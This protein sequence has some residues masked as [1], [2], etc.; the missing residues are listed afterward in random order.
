MPLANTSANQAIKKALSKKRLFYVCRDAERAEAGL[1]LK[2][3]N[4]HIITNKSF[5][6]QKLH[7]LYPNQIH[8]ISKNQP[9]STTDLLTHNKT[10]KLIATNDLVMVFKPTTKTEILCQQLNWSLINPPAKLAGEAEEK[11]SQIAWLGDLKKYLPDT[12]IQILKNLSY[13]NQPFILQ[14]NRAHTGSGTI[15][16]SSKKILNELKLKFPERQVRIVKYIDGSVFTVNC[17]VVGNNTIPGNISYQITGLAPFTDNPYATV[18]NDWQLPKKILNSDTRKQIHNLA[19]SIGQNF[20]QYQWRGLFGIDVIVE[21]KTNRLYLIEINARQPA[22]T[23]FESYLQLQ[24][25]HNAT[26]IF[27]LHLAGLLKLNIKDKNYPIKA[28]GQIVQRLTKDISS[29]PQP[30]IISQPKWRYIFYNNTAPGSDLLRLQ[31]NEGIMTDHNH[32]NNLGNELSIF[33]SLIK[34]NKSIGVK[35]AGLIIIKNNKILL[36]K[37]N[38][39]NYEYYVIP[40]GGVAKN[41]IDET[42]AIREV[43]EETDLKCNINLQIKPIIYNKDNKNEIYFFTEKC[44]GRVSLNG[45]EKLRHHTSNSYKP[46]WLSLDQLP[47]INLLPIEIKKEIIKRIKKSYAL[48]QSRTTN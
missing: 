24:N 46:I 5:W 6:S 47:K 13:S 21:N 4:Y 8:Q 20:I 29:L 37:R 3:P 18:G 39:Y 44:K 35:R 17:A 19:K 33:V 30:K 25:N 2:L 16:I 31:I 15:L 28:G 27:A 38:R 32:L 43:K 40:G 11:I 10:K 1:Y 26:T 22:S 9:L 7:K 23:C 48:T 14:Y 36:M 45:E 34:Q 41:E 12:K 42:T